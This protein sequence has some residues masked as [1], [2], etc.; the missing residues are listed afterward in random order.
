MATGTPLRVLTADIQDLAITN[1]KIGL[2][3]VDT[4]Q[5]A[6]LAVTEGKIGNLAVTNAKIN[7]L[8]ATKITAGDIAT[9]RIQVNAANAVNAGSVTI[10]PGKILISGSTTLSNWRDGSDNTKI[11]GGMLATNSISAN[12]LVIGSRN[13]SFQGLEI[14][15]NYPAANTLYWSAG[16]ISYIKDDGT[17]ADATITS[18]NQ[19][20]S[21]GTLYLYWV[22]DA[23][24]FST[25]TTRATAFSS[26]NL[27]LASYLG[28]N[29]MVANYGRTIIDGSDVL[30]GTI[31]AIK[32][33][34]LELSAITA[35]LG[36]ITAGKID[37]GTGA[38]SYH[39]DTSGNLWLGAAAFVD[40]SFSV[41]NAGVVKARA[42]DIG[43]WILTANGLADNAT[44]ANAKILLDKT[45]TLIRVG[46]VAAGYILIDGNNRLIKSSN[47]T[48]GA[49]G[50][51][52]DYAGNLEVNNIDAR[53]SFRCSVFTYSSILAFN[54]SGW[55]VPASGKLY[56]D[57]TSV[58][59]PTTFNIDIED[60]DGMTHAAAGALWATNDQIRIKEPVG[61]GVQDLWVTISSVSDQTTFWRLVVVKNSPGAGT[62]YTFTKGG[63]GLNYKQ[64]NNVY[65]SILLTADATYSPRVSLYTHPTSPWNGLTERL[66]FGNLN[67]F[68]GYTDSLYGLAI[69]ET[70]SYFKYDPTNKLR[71]KGTITITNPGD[72]NT[73]TLTNGAGW[74]DDTTANLKRRVFVAEPTTPYNI[75]DL[76]ASGTVL[77]KCKTER[78]TGAYQ[79]GDWELATGYTDD[80]VAN[81]KITTFIQASIPTSISAGDLWIDSDDGNKLYRAVIVGADEIKAGEWVVIPTDFANING[82]TK[83]A[84]NATVGATWGTNLNSIPATLGTP[85]GQG[86]FLSAT[87]LGY[88]DSPNWKTYMD[89]SGN[90]YL[91]G[92]SGPLQW[93]AAAST[94]SI[95]NWSFDTVKIWKDG[96]TDALSAGMAPADYPFYAG[97]KYADRANASF[98]VTPDGAVFASSA[99]I[100]GALT[101]EA[102]SSIGAGYISAG[103]ITSKAITLALTPGGGDVKLQA[104]KTDFGD[105]TSGF[106]LGIDDSDGDKPKF[107]LGDV[108]TYFNF[109]PGKMTYKGRIIS[110]KAGFTEGTPAAGIGD[111]VHF[112][113]S[114]GKY[115][116][117]NPLT[118]RN[119]VGL[120]DGDGNVIRLGPCGGLAGLTANA[121][122]YLKWPTLDLGVDTNVTYAGSFDVRQ[123]LVDEFSQAQSF[124]GQV[125]KVIA[126]VAL[127]MYIYG[128]GPTCTG[129]Y[130]TLKKAGA[131]FNATLARSET[132]PIADIPNTWVDIKNNLTYFRFFDPYPLEAA[133]QYMICVCT[134]SN[135]VDPANYIRVRGRASGNGYAGG[136]RYYSTGEAYGIPEEWEFWV[137]PADGS[138]LYMQI[139]WFD[140]DALTP[141]I[142]IA[143]PFEHV[144]ADVTC[145]HPIIKLGRASSTTE[146]DLNIERMQTISFYED[147]INE[148]VYTSATSVE[149]I[150]NHLSTITTYGVERLLLLY[151]AKTGSL[152]HTPII[153]P[154]WNFNSTVFAWDSVTTYYQNQRPFRSSFIFSVNGRGQL[155]FGFNQDA[156]YTTT[157]KGISILGG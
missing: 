43:T 66:R 1:A 46:A 73:N 130:L 144:D 136:G 153:K 129:V 103:T 96:A 91:G 125:G 5:I 33:N 142:T 8:N 54:G 92:V 39:F 56:A 31:T 105:T 86:L 82:T 16:I 2:L 81:S 109:E 102:G 116:L 111:A 72:I 140:V 61:T 152:T 108:T 148:L 124:P 135:I 13:V 58:D 74:T 121:M 9:A 106:I 59:S 27:V 37:I 29:D 99:T 40:G 15:A 150:Y 23:T 87:Y 19:L 34:V 128:T 127:P 134:D 122:Y 12:I 126:V 154:C 41:S 10:E 21:S 114:D 141:N 107:E 50:F 101:A 83:P 120:K 90:F 156:G 44:E 97:K 71:I 64:G 89:S 36:S 57:F 85:S 42:G 84:D 115:Y 68:L 93:A 17:T 35:N 149:M 119:I 49:S 80:A 24:V 104:G 118:R 94:L 3:A 53:G 65:G 7:D 110:V 38:T 132:I 52:A 98:R 25:T 55:W 151:R 14:S 20:W 70:D 11:N 62:N 157:I 123:D 131:G 100:T 139:W 88:Y 146:L 69:G 76:W 26:N 113:T 45:N 138:D 67:G 32:L 30:T 155:G 147:W 51:Q 78:L 75:G 79:A 6:N 60:P 145:Y 143:H 63:A 47:Y 95:G 112:E 117:A 18:G 133:T 22:K 48:S 137:D 77:K 4:A 28:G